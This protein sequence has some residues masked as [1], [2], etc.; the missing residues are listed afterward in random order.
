M[1]IYNQFIK[2]CNMYNQKV[3]VLEGNNT[4]DCKLVEHI[5]NN[6]VHYII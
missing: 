6:K 3:I 2:Y 1:E 5:A 4:I